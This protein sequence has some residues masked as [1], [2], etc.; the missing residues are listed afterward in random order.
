[1][2][3]VIKVALKKGRAAGMLGEAMLKKK[4]AGRV[5][6]KVVPNVMKK[7]ARFS[8]G[9]QQRHQHIVE[10]IKTELAEWA[11]AAGDTCAPSRSASECPLCG[12]V[13]DRR[14]N[15]LRHVES[16][17]SGKLSG[18]IHALES[19]YAQQPHPVFMQVARALYDNDALLDR[20]PGNYLSRARALLSEWL[21]FQTSANGDDSLFTNLG[22]RDRNMVL[23]LTEDGPQFWQ[24]GA[25]K[26]VGCQTWGAG[27][28]YTKGF[29]NLYMRHLLQQGG[30]TA[31][32]M[33]A[34]R[35]AWQ[36]KGCEVTYLMN[37][38]TE[39]LA[40]MSCHLMESLAVDT[41]RQGSCER[42]ANKLEYKSL[43]IDATYK[44]AM[45]MAGQARA[46]AVSWTSI[47]GLRGTPLGLVL[48]AGEGPREL[49]SAMEQAV[50]EKFRWQVEHV[51]SDSCS[52]ELLRELRK[53][54]PKVNLSLDAMH[55]CFGVDKLAKAWKV[56]PTV[57]GLVM[58]SI[59]GK[60]NVSCPDMASEA[61]YEGARDVHVAAEAKAWV[62]R[63][64]AGDMPMGQATKALK[65][66]DPNAP[67]RSLAEF[68]RLLA[69]VVVVYP[70]RMDAKLDG[71]TL[72]G[73]F[74]YACTPE[75]FGWY[76][77]NIKYRS[78]LPQK[79]EG[80][81]A[82]GTTR[83]EQLHA[84]LNAH[85]RGTVC[86]S[87]RML[88]AQAAAW[89]A[90]E[91]AAYVRAME[92]KTTKK[93]GRADAI[94]AVTSSIQVFTDDMWG[95]FVG[96]GQTPWVARSKAAAGRAPRSGPSQ[97]QV[98]IYSAIREKTVKR[99]RLSVFQPGR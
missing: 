80:F 27:H 70:E 33:R 60:F 20:E 26:L 97:S 88:R 45:K 66:M 93:V 69:A 59:M 23:V 84:R 83:N 14:W 95:D 53:V 31:P 3:P 94:G 79:L 65:D 62:A 74:G 61:L 89:L 34:M 38:H 44:L 90:A 2:G 71:S 68:A 24:S 85:W 12:R 35:L 76:M 19:N 15:M 37:R 50:P 29:A 36:E 17:T 6:A 41:L 5:P 63:I 67:M 87:K 77:N 11:R 99:A 42:L 92:A 81:M 55:L 21:G 32:S 28:R 9:Q 1:M 4:P 49:R 52:P 54:F 13:V 30:L 57:V 8:S 43:S 98:A 82:A 91:M 22:A 10:H 73:S 72:R 25:P 39:H 7:P 56:R 40:E 47:V 75:R 16:H 51:A 96:Q 86:V 58:R 46:G 78:S 18:L 48:T 64:C